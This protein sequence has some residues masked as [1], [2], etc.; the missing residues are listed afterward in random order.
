MGLLGRIASVFSTTKPDQE[1][2][3]LVRKTNPSSVESTV[4]ES[5]RQ[6]VSTL[7]Y[8]TSLTARGYPS[9]GGDGNYITPM[10]NLGEIGKTLDVESFFAASVRRHREL[11]MKEGWHLHGTDK[12]AIAYVKK[13]FE[14]IELITGEPIS[15]IVRELLTNLIAYG[16]AIL[17]IKRDPLRSSGSPI[18]MFGKTMQPI[19]GLYPADP[20]SM[21]VKK[22]DFG[23]PVEW[24][25]KI[26]DS[27]KTRKFRASDVV[28][29]HLDRKSGFTFGTPYI[30]P[31]LE[32]IRALRRL[33]ELAELVTHKH[34]FP[35]FHAKV[36]SKD[37]P[38]GYITSPDGQTLSEVDVI[39]AQVDALP[40]EGGLVTS[41]RVEINMLG[42]EGQVL[43]LEPY[44]SHFESRVLGG[45]RLSGIDLGR[46]DTANKATAQTVT[47]N[48]VDACSEIQ[49]VFSEMFTAKIVDI[50]LLEGGFNLVSDVRV[51]LRFPDID[52][53]EARAH[54]NHGIQLFMQN[55]ITEDELRTDY[56]NREPY[57]DG[58]RG[59]TFHELYTK[60]LAEIGAMNEQGPGSSQGSANTVT[61]KA[62]PTNQHGTATTKK[63]VAQN[64]LM[65]KELFNQ[66]S[67]S[68]SEMC[69][70]ICGL[71]ARNSKYNKVTKSNDIK[72]IL[73]LKTDAMMSDAKKYLLPEIESGAKKARKDIHTNKLVSKDDISL[74]LSKHIRIPLIKLNRKAMIMLKIDLDNEVKLDLDPAKASSIFD[75]LKVE[76]DMMTAQT[77]DFAY[78]YGYMTTLQK[79]GRKNIRVMYNSIN[80]NGTLNLEKEVVMPIASVSKRD[81]SGPHTR[82]NTTCV[83]DEEIDTDKG[84]E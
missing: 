41:E 9:L 48:L 29:F 64:S 13:R 74:F 83:I 79:A 27:E 57:A 84:D 50:I 40:P 61:N 4:K 68:W 39:G 77:T 7:Y 24:K 8:K 32:D 12:E 82:L 17:V 62:R 14:E 44:L 20:T 65:M 58:D 35:L 71:S 19:S 51:S 2:L 54:Q 18:R 6:A 34:T 52:R 15:A 30:I 42:T 3:R 80:E 73:I 70:D 78:K 22:N 59:N 66:F 21:A 45:L 28:H 23:R 10:Y 5:P 60:P 53:E 1:D 55:A 11:S 69:E 36:G 56:L 81:V 75:A 49:N 46:G 31:V 76:L 47:K 38:A 63:S 26:W 33:E 37:K 72:K 25:Q 16:N 43:D 67:Y